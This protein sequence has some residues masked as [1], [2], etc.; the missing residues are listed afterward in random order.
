MVCLTKIAGPRS[1]ATVFMTETAPIQGW[2]SSIASAFIN[3]DF[4][5]MQSDIYRFH[6]SRDC[7]HDRETGG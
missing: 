5:E 3:V 1:D 6:V 2:V 7:P 4:L